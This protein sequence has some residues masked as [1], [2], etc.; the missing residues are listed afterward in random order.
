MSKQKK[1]EKKCRSTETRRQRTNQ[2]MFEHRL[3][4]ITINIPTLHTHEPAGALVSTCFLMTNY[5]RK[6]KNRRVSA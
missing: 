1:K 3:Y 5:C 6:D 2:F 4:T